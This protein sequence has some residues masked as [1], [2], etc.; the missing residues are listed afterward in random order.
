MPRTPAQGIGFL[1]GFWLAFALSPLMVK[2]AA[3]GEPANLA[4]L[5][6]ELFARVNRVRSEHH[7][8]PLERRSDL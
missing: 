1:I 4:S 7:L 8:I 3:S 5:E 6:A 2:T